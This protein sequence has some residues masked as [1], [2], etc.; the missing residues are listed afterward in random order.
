MKFK[1]YLRYSLAAIC[2]LCST[3][4]NF[5]FGANGHRIVAQIAENHLTPAAK[6]KIRL[7][8]NGESL[9]EAATWPDE[10]RSDINWDYAKKWHFLTVEDDQ[11][12]E[13]V[14]KKTSPTNGM[15]NNV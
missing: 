3:V 5:G 9:P 14:L 12:V 4:E 2:L 10:I 7:I 11:S 6:E 13:D 8:L 1:R 15:P